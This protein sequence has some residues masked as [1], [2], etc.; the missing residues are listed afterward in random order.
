MASVKIQTDTKIIEN[1]KRVYFFLCVISAISRLGSC[2][3]IM[4]MIAHVSPCYCVCV[5][6]QCV[7]VCVC[8]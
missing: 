2:V 8:Y 5:Y 1:N 3:A 6:V 4:Y 7:C